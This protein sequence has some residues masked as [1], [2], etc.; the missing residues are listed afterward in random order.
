MKKNIIAA[1][2]VAVFAVANVNAQNFES[3]EPQAEVTSIETI[4]SQLNEEDAQSF[5]T[6]YQR[7]MKQIEC[8]CA[9]KLSD[10]E[11]AGSIEDIKDFYYEMF[12][13]ILV[14]EQND[15]AMKSVSL[16]Y[17]YNRIAK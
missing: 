10:G 6:M 12:S 4:V 13:N 9:Q 16:E 11:K 1:A 15:A 3:E 14:T 7:M 17:I 8:I 2:L 5:I